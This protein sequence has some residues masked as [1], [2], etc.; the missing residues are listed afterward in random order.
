MLA[1]GTI[2]H[3]EAKTEIRIKNLLGIGGQGPAYE[4]LVVKTGERVVV[5]VFADASRRD[6]YRKRARLLVDMNLAAAC[7][8]FCSPVNCLQGTDLA[9]HVAPFFEGASL[10]EIVY[11]PSGVPT[12]TLSDNLAVAIAVS[13]AFAM[14][15]DIIGVVH[16]DIQLG[17]ILCRCHDATIELAVIDFDNW[18]RI[19]SKP[20]DPPPPMA[21]H[22]E[23]MAPEI[24]TEFLKGKPPLPTLES[25]RF[26]L[27]VLLQEVILQRHPG[28]DLVGDE[29]HSTMSQPWSDDPARVSNSS[30]SDSGYPAS[31]LNAEIAGLFRRSIHP[32]P[33]QRASATE[34]RR[35]LC[36]A[37]RSVYTC[38]LCRGVFIADA[39]T[40]HCPVCR[41]T[42]PLWELSGTG[43]RLCLNSTLR[44]IGRSDLGDSPKVSK[45]HCIFRRMGPGMEVEAVGMNPTC[46]V[47]SGTETPLVKGKPA[48]LEAGDR[49][50]IANVEV[51][52]QLVAA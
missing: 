4:G 29:F 18:A 7:R 3:T 39:W 2:V 21:G 13:H 49:L 17:N 19:H 1:S 48:P 9:G 28:I 33:A 46:L 20:E 34:W 23:Y 11:P 8:A 25:D 35:A 45:Q 22:L 12:T 41:L 30:T 31:V 38:P 5:K 14:L 50:R 15:H 37:A 52:V 40:L 32:Q 44:V 43:S 36:E 6:D 16:G 27:A 47:R 51:S 42:F 24:R 26:A 10:A